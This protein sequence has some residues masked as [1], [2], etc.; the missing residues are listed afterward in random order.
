MT[1][2]PSLSLLHTPALYVAASGSLTH[3]DF[4]ACVY[5]IDNTKNSFV[6]EDYQ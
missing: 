1:N 3:L 6:S 4:F 2:N 5:I